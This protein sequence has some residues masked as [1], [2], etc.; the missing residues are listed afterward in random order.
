[1]TDEGQMGDPVDAIEM[2]QGMRDLASAT[3]AFYRQLVDEGFGKS[4]AIKLTSAWISGLAGS[5]KT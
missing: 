1:M 3:M 4:D 2:A 5:Q